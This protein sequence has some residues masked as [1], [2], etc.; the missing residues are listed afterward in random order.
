MTSTAIRAIAIAIAAIALAAST[1]AA[2]PVR[3]PAGIRTSSL[4]GTVSPG[5]DLRNPDQRAPAPPA[6]QILRASGP[7]AAQA[8]RAATPL[9]ADDD[10]PSPLVYILPGAA[11]LGMLGAGLGYARLSRGPASA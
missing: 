3:D 4:A 6:A 8:P 5:Q 10:G 9:P 11:L 1:A 2:Q 7:A